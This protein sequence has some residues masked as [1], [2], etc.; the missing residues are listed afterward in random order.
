MNYYL[1]L[2]ETFYFCKKYSINF[3]IIPSSALVHLSTQLKLNQISLH[4]FHKFIIISY[5]HKTVSH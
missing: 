5:K 2:Y 3:R 4:W 1:F